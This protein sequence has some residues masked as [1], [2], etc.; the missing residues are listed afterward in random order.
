VKLI[1]NHISGLLFFL[2]I[3]Y[4]YTHLLVAWFQNTKLKIENY[5]KRRERF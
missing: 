5:K 2:L 3:L 4:F 1:F